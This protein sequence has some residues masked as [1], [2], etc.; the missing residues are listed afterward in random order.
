MQW[1]EIS[2]FLTV[3][4]GHQTRNLCFTSTQYHAKSIVTILTHPREIY[5]RLWW[6]EIAKITKSACLNFYY[7][8]HLMNWLTEWST[9]TFAKRICIN[10]TFLSKH[11]QLNFLQFDLPW[12]YSNQF[13]N[14]NKDEIKIRSFVSNLD[15]KF[16]FP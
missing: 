3:L 1:P 8:K 2:V 15:N 5:V 6:G 9:K 12:M 14:P 11:N 7:H 10:L 13:S 4:R 16:S